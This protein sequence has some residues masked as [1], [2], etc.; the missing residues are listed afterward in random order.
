MTFRSNIV[1]CDFIN[2]FI[3]Q[4]QGLLLNLINQKILYCFHTVVW[5]KIILHTKVE[6]FFDHLVVKFV[7]KFIYE[8][9]FYHIIKLDCGESF[10]IVLPTIIFLTVKNYY[11]CIFIEGFSK[12]SQYLKHIIN[13]SYFGMI[14]EYKS[15]DFTFL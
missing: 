11:L 12:G 13:I 5:F 1:R 14:I 9:F 7:L 4:N 10:K 8:L 3:N 6:E 15:I 2:K